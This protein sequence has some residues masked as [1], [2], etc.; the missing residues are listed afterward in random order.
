MDYITFPKKGNI[1]QV[2]KKE[3]E[4]LRL[5]GGLKLI[6]VSLKSQTPKV[7]WLM[8]IV[9]DANLKVHRQ[10]FN[11]LIGL[12][13]GNLNGEDIIFTENS[14]VEKILQTDNSFY[15]EALDGI[16][17]LNRGK[18]YLDINNENVFFNPIFTTTVHSEI[19]E[20]I[21]RPFQGN[22]ILSGI[23]TY[24]ELLVTE[25]TMECPKLTA[26]LRKKNPGY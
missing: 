12:Q 15:K 26:V 4:K 1:P 16:T 2:S 25:R 23:K 11:S 7:H 6:N 20:D 10:L 18:H 8:H 9:T 21:I 3:M 22:P 17:K 5:D 19:H 24:G 13:S 14:Y